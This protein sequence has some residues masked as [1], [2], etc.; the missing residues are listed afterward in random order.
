[1]TR[2]FPDPG[3][4]ATFKKSLSGLRIAKFCAEGG[5]PFVLNDLQRGAGR[6]GKLIMESISEKICRHFST[7]L[8][9]I[10]LNQRRHLIGISP[11]LLYISLCFER[12]YGN[13]VPRIGRGCQLVDHRTANRAARIA[14]AFLARSVL[15][16]FSLIWYAHLRAKFLTLNHE[17]CVGQDAIRFPAVSLCL[18]SLRQRS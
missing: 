9:T 3:G 15:R 1:M 2:I 12:P 8:G 10:P 16:I 5:A 11:T 17:P 7:A 13:S 14:L 4:H 18:Q 6:R